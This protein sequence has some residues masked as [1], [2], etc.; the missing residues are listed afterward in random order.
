MK[1]VALVYP[2]CKCQKFWPIL[3]A[4]KGSCGNWPCALTPCWNNSSSPTVAF[5]FQKCAFRQKDIGTQLPMKDAHC[6]YSHAVSSHW[7][8]VSILEYKGFLVQFCPQSHTEREAILLTLLC[9]SLAV[10]GLGLTWPKVTVKLKMCL[11]LLNKNT[12][13]S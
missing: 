2:C 3:P 12:S 7:A 13:S 4:E 9:L 11:Q 1:T 5:S 10:H 8:H 6:L